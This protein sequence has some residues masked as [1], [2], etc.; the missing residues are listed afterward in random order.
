MNDAISL[1]RQLGFGE[2]EA[3][4]YA[5][6]LQRHPLNGYELARASG[7]PRANVYAVL[8]RLEE[9]GA[10]LRVETPEG[11]RYS[12]VPPDELTQGLGHGCRRRSPPRSKR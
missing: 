6:L 2:Y 8:E 12:P 9:R 5:A 10:V 4:A 7:I 11:T 1:L 3:K